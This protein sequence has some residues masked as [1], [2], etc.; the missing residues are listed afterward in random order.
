MNKDFDGWKNKKAHLNSKSQV[1]KFNER[2]IWWCSIGHNIGFEQDGKGGDYARPVLIIRKFNKQLFFG[3][4]LSTRG[5]DDSP[6]YYKFNFKNKQS[7]ALL[8]QVRIFDSKRLLNIEGTIAKKTYNE[9]LSS[10]LK[11]FS[12]K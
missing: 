9:I 3:I 6:Y 7:Y 11:L 5:K 8:S 2:E 1:K 12:K 4:P 10:Y